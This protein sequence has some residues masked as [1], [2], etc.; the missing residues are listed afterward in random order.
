[1]NRRNYFGLGVLIIIL[2]AAGGF[3]YWQWSEVQKFKEKLA[4]DAKHLE[5]NDKQV[6]EDEL[7]PAAPGKKWVPH[8]DHFHEVPVDAPDVWQD[9]PIVDASDDTVPTETK[10][11]DGPLTYHAELLETNPVKA[12][13]AQAKERGHWSERWI[14]PFPPDDEE[15]QAFA[16][17]AYLIVHYRSTGE[18]DTPEA[19]QNEREYN[20]LLY[21]FMDKEG[22]R[23]TPRRSDLLKLSW[24]ILHA[25]DIENPYYKR[26]NFSL[27]LK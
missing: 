20:L 11:Y 3:I 24:A 9:K 14:P 7:P 10:T 21:A 23:G 8:G 18:I 19:V 2:I 6:A 15:A 12:L 27:P 17:T 5:G 1:M 16:R 4:Q 13:R 22:Y 25:G 26:S